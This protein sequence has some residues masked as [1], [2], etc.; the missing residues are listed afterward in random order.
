[1]TAPY[2]YRLAIG[3]TSD[4]YR[5]QQPNPLGG[6]AIMPFARLQATKY[7]NR[8]EMSELF[9]ADRAWLDREL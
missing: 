4:G 6:V 3:S 2:R 9:I 1:V 5:L 7:R 8:H